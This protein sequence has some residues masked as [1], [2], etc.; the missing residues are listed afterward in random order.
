MD[1]KNLAVIRQTFA[2][3]V[4]THKV[5]E[6]ATER[7]ERRAKGYK[8]IHITLVSVV[9]ILLALQAAHLDTPIFSL[10]GI[11]VAV[12]EIVFLIVQLTFNMERQATLHKTYALKYLALRDKY[13]L[14]IADIMGEKAPR[15]EIVVRRNAL[16]Q[17]YQN[18]CDLA[19]QTG[20][21]EY[22][23]AQKRLND[24]GAIEGEQFTWSDEEIDRFL[25]K[26][27]RL[28]K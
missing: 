6:V 26:E 8:W 24:R 4:F 25:P 15:Q 9:L 12:A 20:S 17:E 14:L 21:A 28:K 5:Q 22:T 1:M 7:K 13:I 23:E 2:Q 10:V 27:L 16:L 3:T 11:G 18:I 19:P